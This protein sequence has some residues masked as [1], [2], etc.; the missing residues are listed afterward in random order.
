MT[1]PKA[2]PREIARRFVS[3]QLERL[4][5]CDDYHELSFQDPLHEAIRATHDDDARGMPQ[6]ELSR[7]EKDF[8]H[9]LPPKLKPV[10]V[11]LRNEYVDQ[12][13]VAEEGAFLVGLYAGRGGAQ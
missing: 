3:D 8:E 6:E 11:T 9:Q 7:L 5:R 4:S 12:A 2:D 13:A 10:F 1:T